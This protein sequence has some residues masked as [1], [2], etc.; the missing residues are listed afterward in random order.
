M[1]RPIVLASCLLATAPLAAAAQSPDSAAFVIL[2][3]ADTVAIEQVTRTATEIRGELD[4]RRN[5]AS[6]GYHAVLAPDATVPLVEITVQE[7]PA[8][9]KERARVAQR[10]RVIFRA[11]SVA[12]DEASNHGLE[13]R[14]LPT[15]T[16][17]IPY[18]NLSA[19][20]L[21]QTLRRAAVLGA[22]EVEVPL[23]NLS[24]SAKGAG[25]TV[26]AKLTRVGADSLALA[27]GAVEYRLRVDGS[28]RL[29]GGGIPAQGLSFARTSGS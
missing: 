21:E 6:E 2:R 29:L 11:D 13:T 20:M 25:Q 28:G 12:V 17:A 4:F 22:G 27:I 18:L 7:Q 10:T 8:S 14:V 26:R 1:S 24:G 3:G 19:G 23:F 16:G 9:E 15:E 5:G